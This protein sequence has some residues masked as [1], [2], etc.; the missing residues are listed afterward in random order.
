MECGLSNQMTGGCK[1]HFMLGLLQSKGTFF[2]DNVE[3]SRQIIIWVM[4]KLHVP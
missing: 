3:E 1:E 4:H 2:D